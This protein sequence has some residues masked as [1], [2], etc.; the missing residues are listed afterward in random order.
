M[1]TIPEELY[2]RIQQLSDVVRTDLRRKG[3][4][5]PIKNKNGTITIGKYTIVK[6]NDGS[7]GILDYTSESVV[8]GIN[9]PQTAIIV[10]NK[11]ALGYYK[12]TDLLDV[13]RRYGSADF[14]ERLY[15]RALTQK[16][17]DVISIYVTK[18]E[19]AKYKKNGYKQSIDKSFEKLLK[20][21]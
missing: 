18:Y 5:I 13:D 9:L 7:Y 20:L 4:V 19:I 3:L 14:E 12:D 1:N 8:N 11:L 6:S 17:H 16:S 21:V 15:K 2:H 10:A